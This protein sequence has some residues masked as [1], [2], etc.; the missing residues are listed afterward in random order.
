MSA[1]GQKRTYAVHHAMS[2]LPPKAGMCG[3]TTD[4]RFGSKADIRFVIQSLD[5]REREQD[6]NSISKKSYAIL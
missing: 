3:A 1:L 2:A 4:V 6:G 5:R